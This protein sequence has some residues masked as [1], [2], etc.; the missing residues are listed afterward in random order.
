MSTIVTGTHNGVLRIVFNRPD[1][2]NALTVEMYE[3][4]NEAFDLAAGDP[5]IKALLFAGEGGTY[6]AGNDL[7][8]FLANP[9]K[10]EE[11]PVFQFI[12]NLA[13][14]PKPM[15]AAVQ[16][17]AVGVGTTMLMHCD[18]VYAADDAKFS[19]P[20]VNLGL[21]PEAAVSYLLPR[22]AGYQRAAEKLLLGEPFGAEEGEAMGFVNKI[23]PPDQVIA[24]AARQAEKIAALPGPSI[25]ATKMFLKGGKKSVEQK[26][27]FERM[28]E[29]AALFQDMLTGPAA[30]EAMA[31]F[32][33]KR[34]PD[35]SSIE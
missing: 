8:D 14:C 12:R 20:F 33:Q 16:G 32:M 22:I 9:P 3:A 28:E 1:K 19:L 2:K 34:K 30:L 27:I 29:E 31:A 10:G 18:L 26:A 35:F 24:Y 11:A 4:L 15:I 7:Q 21:C 17:Y 13:H 6:T 23:L 5:G 25:R